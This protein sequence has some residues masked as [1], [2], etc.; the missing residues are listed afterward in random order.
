M[1]SE[2]MVLL[3]NFRGC[4]GGLVLHLL[5]EFVSWVFIAVLLHLGE[6]TL[7]WSHGSINLKSNGN[8]KQMKR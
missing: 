1:G 6:V 2:A 7:L 8:E 4:G 3:S 5:K